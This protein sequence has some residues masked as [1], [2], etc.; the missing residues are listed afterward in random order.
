VCLCRAL[1]V[2]FDPILIR[3]DLYER[4]PAQL[5]EAWGSIDGVRWWHW[6]RGDHLTGPKTRRRTVGHLHVLAPEYRAHD[7]TW[8]VAVRLFSMTARRMRSTDYVA[9]KRL[10]RSATP[11]GGGFGDWS[12]LGGTGDT[13]VMNN[14][15]RTM[16]A[17]AP[18]CDVLSIGVTLLDL[19]L[20]GAQ[21]PLFERERAMQDLWGS[22]TGS[23]PSAA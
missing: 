7:R 9:G 13:V 16:W 20:K 12:P 17:E 23:T 8:G 6:I 11:T 10:C 3:A 2:R 14:V 18:V 4:T 22:S 1:T 5:R 21:M 19:E 15:L